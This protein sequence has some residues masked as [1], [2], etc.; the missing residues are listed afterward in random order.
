VLRYAGRRIAS[1]APILLAVIT[2]TFALVHSVP[3]GPFDGERSLPPEVEANLRAAYHLDKPLYVQF[4]RYLKGL[5]HGDLGPSFRYR[6]K[7]VK[8]LIGDSFPISAR[9]GGAAIGVALVLGLALGTFAALRRNTPVDGLVMGIAM[10]GIAVP[11]FVT[12]PMLALLFGVY[13]KVLPVAGWS[14]GALP[15][16]VLPVTA[17]ALP[18]VAIIARLARAS[19]IEVLQSNYIRTA[20]AKGLAPGR[21]VLVHAMPAAIMPVV[22]F[23]GP[24]VAGV[25]TGSVVV[26]QIFGLPGLGRH[27]INAALNRDYTL[28]MGIVI[29]YAT[30]VVAL[31]LVVDLLQAALDPRVRLS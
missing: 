26:E 16:L 29:F 14:E 11:V 21:I 3:G 20:R 4:G 13:L 31:N 5:M 15:N 24:A 10:T 2:L 28:V 25:L 1:L 17:L 18:Y 27:F 9:I 7:S 8:E 12:A 6:D 30:L 23:L 19:M 22:S